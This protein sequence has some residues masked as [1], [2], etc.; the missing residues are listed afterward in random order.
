MRNSETGEFEL[1]VG[2]RQLLSGFFIVVLLFAVAF[3]MGYIVGRNSSPSAK[4]Q[5]ETGF[6]AGAASQ[7]PETRPQPASQAPAAG[8]APS[9]PGGTPADA[10]QGG[11]ATP[12][13]DTAP[14]P[15]TQPERGPQPGTPP[16]AAPTV[17]PPGSG[18]TPP[19]AVP[20]SYWQVLAT[21]SQTSAEA[22]RQTMKDKGFPASLQPGPNSLIRVLIGP[23]NDKQ[24][25]GRA[26]TDLEN[27]G[28]HPVLMK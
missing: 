10:A 23:Y 16:A 5:T 19:E 6:S 8:G 28:V 3:S 13:A 21:A 18:G 24:S 1:L 7:T 2:N 27:A 22:M 12:P 14:Q 4:L 11:A 20:G 9:G 17:V 15:S 25:L 26:K